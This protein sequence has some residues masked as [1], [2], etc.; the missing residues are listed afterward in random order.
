MGASPAIRSRSAVG[1]T[2][3]WNAAFFLGQFVTPILIGA[4]VAAVGGLPI[5]V[6]VVGIAAA[7]VGLLVWLAARRAPREALA[8]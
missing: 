1:S 6:G 4:L 2:G 5:A 7:V 8:D 3:W